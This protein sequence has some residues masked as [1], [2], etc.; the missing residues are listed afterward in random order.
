MEYSFSG[1]G[2]SVFLEPYLTISALGPP[3]KKGDG[4][5]SRVR[6][7]AKLLATMQG[8]ASASGIPK[9][10]SA[11]ACHGCLSAEECFKVTAL[12]EKHVAA[13]GWL[14]KRHNVHATT[15]FSLFDA[16]AVMAAAKPAVMRAAMPSLHKLFFAGA[17]DIGLTLNDLFY[18]RYSAEVEGGQRSLEPHRDGSLV[19]FSIMLSDPSTDFDGGGTLLVGKGET[20]SPTH[21]GD[22]VAHSGKVLHAGAN[23]T[24][25]R[26]DLLVGFVTV[27]GPDVND[28]F[29]QSPNV[30]SAFEHQRLD[31]AIV[32]GALVSTAL[33][34]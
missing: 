5:V 9:L 18:V 6:G 29:L 19:S 3:T 11:H 33:Q 30:T 7:A 22:L 27:H 34:S 25:G 20:L 1:Q 23:V 16:P 10:L 24:R 32:T 8:G 2:D 17:E 15:D 13:N 12:A 14:T 28:A 26:R 31:A 21:R 4:R